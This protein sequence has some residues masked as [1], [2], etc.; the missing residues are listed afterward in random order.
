MNLLCFKRINKEIKKKPKKSKKKNKIYSENYKNIST[1]EFIKECIACYNCKQIF[2]LGSNEL[3]I[4]CA[5]CNNF[6]HCGIAGKCIGKNCSSHNTLIGGT[7]SLSWCIHC[8][9]KIKINEEK[10]NGIGFCICNECNK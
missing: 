8:V 7:H 10:E 9:P 1:E 2:D 3:K 6:F 5:G 4:H